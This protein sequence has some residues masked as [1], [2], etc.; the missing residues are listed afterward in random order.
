MR[1]YYLLYSIACGVQ[2]KSNRIY[3]LIW[4]GTFA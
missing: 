3:L 4:K 2:N 1:R